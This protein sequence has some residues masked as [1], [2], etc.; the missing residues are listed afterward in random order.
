MLDNP[1]ELIKTLPETPGVYLWYNKN[2]EIIYVGKAKNL[3]NRVS[4]YLNGTA[5]NSY[6]T[7]KLL[8]DI[9]SLELIEL[10]TDNDALNKER[11][12]IY[13][14][15]P[16]YNVKLPINPYFPYIHVFYNKKIHT[17]EI[18]K[19]NGNVNEWNYACFGP[20]IKKNS[21]WED[22]KKYLQLH[23]LNNENITE[24]KRYNEANA[25]LKLKEIKE[26]FK[27]P[28]LLIK[29]LRKYENN[30]RKNFNFELAETYK[31]VASVFETNVNN[32]LYLK[33]PLLSKTPYDILNFKKYEYKN[34]IY[35][36]FYAE[37]FINKKQ[38]NQ[39]SEIIK[40]NRDIDDN[41][42]L[43]ALIKWYETINNLTHWIYIDNQYLKL[44]SIYEND[45]NFKPIENIDVFETMEVIMNELFKSK[46]ETAISYY[47]KEFLYQTEMLSN[48]SDILN[49]KNLKNFAIIDNSFQNKKDISCGVIHYYQNA[50]LTNQFVKKLNTEIGNYSD[51]NY[52][53]EIIA[54]YI[55]ERKDQYNNLDV[56]F[57][58]GHNQQIKSV[59]S[60]LQQAYDKKIITE[61]KPIFGLKKKEHTFY[62]IVDIDD[63]E[64]LNVKEITKKFFLEKQEIVDKHANKTRRFISKIAMKNSL[65]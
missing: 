42:L 59:L 6:L 10:K 53:K 9:D 18:R 23:L 1:K 33:H 65:K 50:I 46:I 3:K 19:G 2:K 38:S 61:I 16:K 30:A 8:Q 54:K 37:R 14:Y 27:N 13:K 36:L 62:Q 47:Q 22:T 11:E 57:L 4:C 44:P 21:Y 55:K 43:N 52:M 12:L 17:I 64:I 40:I 32:H 49:I 60:I 20:L 34:D 15:N 5:D 26:I 35:V 56:I 48:L 28:D 24:V 51:I 45:F 39:Y 41:E 63:N 58:D 7:P 29:R 25:R 31:N